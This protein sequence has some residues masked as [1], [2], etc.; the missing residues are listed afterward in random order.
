MLPP[1]LGQCV[2]E[3]IVRC[4]EDHPAIDTLPRIVFS[5]EKPA[6]LGSGGG[7]LH[8]K[9][10]FSAETII[11]ALPDMVFSNPPP[12][13]FARA[14]LKGDTSCGLLLLDRK[15]AKDAPVYSSLFSSRGRVN[16]GQGRCWSGIGY[17]KKE[18][19]RDIWNGKT[20]HEFDV[21]E[22]YLLPEIAEGRCASVPYPSGKWF[23]LG[24]IEE[25]LKSEREASRLLPDVWPK[26]LRKH[27]TIGR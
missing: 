21:F 15:R 19:L 14:A 18:L 11:T 6:I 3:Q 10:L 16:K 13:A 9:E 27:P 26:C 17:L 5:E 12:K 25:L 2:R 22:H 4:V 20:P 24:T 7:L 8:A 23:E 1:H